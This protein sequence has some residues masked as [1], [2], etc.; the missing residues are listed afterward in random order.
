MALLIVRSD[1]FNTPLLVSAPPAVQATLLLAG[2]SIVPP[3]ILIAP[4]PVNVP[5]YKPNSP[6]ILIG[7][8]LVNVPP[9]IASVVAAGI[10]VLPPAVVLNVSPPLRKLSDPF[11]SFRSVKAKFKLALFSV[12]SPVPVNSIKPPL[13]KASVPAPSNVPPDQF[14]A[15]PLLVSDAPFC[16]FRLPPASSAVA[17]PALT[18]P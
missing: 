8:L 13:V 7:P 14:R 6:L 9:Y 4:L 16:K 1:R 17:P 12:R 2:I 5:P 18:L 11:G 10:V 3:V 15:P